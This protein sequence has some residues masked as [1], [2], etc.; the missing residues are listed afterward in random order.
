MAAGKYTVDTGTPGTSPVPGTGQLA[1]DTWL[2][3]F[4]TVLQSHPGVQVRADPVRRSRRPVAGACRTSAG[5]PACRRTMLSRVVDALGGRAPESTSSWPAGGRLD[6]QGAGAVVQRGVRSVILPASA[7]SPPRR[8]RGQRAGRDGAGCRSDQHTVAVAT[9][10]TRRCRVTPRRSW[11]AGV[12]GVGQL[13]ELMA[14]IADPSR[15]GPVLVAHAG[16]D[17]AALRRSRRRRRHPRDPGDESLD[18]RRS[19]RRSTAALAAAAALRG[20][21]QPAGA[22]PLLGPHVAV[23]RRPR[24]PPTSPASCRRSPRCSGTAAGRPPRS[25]PRCRWGCNASSRRTG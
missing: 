3:R 25:S 19:L 18:V 22:V 12:D 9:T 20:R 10:S 11:P 14:E 17:P 15:A 21:P 24:Q 1:A 5:T 23:A 4:R 6:R 7:V 8:R 16:R 2:Q 13:P